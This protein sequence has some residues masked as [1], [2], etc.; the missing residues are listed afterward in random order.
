M[1]DLLKG[2]RVAPG[3]AMYLQMNRFTSA[4]LDADGSAETLRASGV[5]LVRDTSLYWK[6][7][8]QGLSG[9]VMTT[10]GKLAHYAAAEL[11]VTCCLADLRACADSAVAGRV[12]GA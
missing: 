11:G 5:R 10:S 7:Q 6:P 2:R 9:R 8:A 3:T 1:G 4:L 12:E